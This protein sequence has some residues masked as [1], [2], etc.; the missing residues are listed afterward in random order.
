MQTEN[1][2]AL[3]DGLIDGQLEHARHRGYFLADVSP[4]HDEEGVD[5]I[6]GGKLRFPD[7]GSQLFG[8]AKTAKPP[9][10]RKMR[11]R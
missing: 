7:H 5:E 4:R 6:R 3:A 2:E 10:A 8:Q 11:C 1:R 9:Y